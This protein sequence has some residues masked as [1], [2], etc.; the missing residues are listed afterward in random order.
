VNF[1]DVT[2]KVTEA[3]LLDYQLYDKRCHLEA[4][5]SKLSELRNF[6]HV[7]SKL[8]DMCKYGVMASQLN[9]FARRFTSVTM[10]Q[11]EVV[12]LAKKMIKAGYVPSKLILKNHRISWMENIFG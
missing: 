2:I 3:G 4:N 11:N 7:D 1:L 9:R 8:A 6:P 12:E 5:G 10:F